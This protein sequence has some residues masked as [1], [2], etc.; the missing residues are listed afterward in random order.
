MPSQKT[1]ENAKMQKKL[2]HINTSNLVKTNINLL[3]INYIQT[4]EINVKNSGSVLEEGVCIFVV[5]NSV[6]NDN[7][8]KNRLYWGGGCCNYFMY[9][10]I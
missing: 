3:I 4:Y 8:T 1:Q 2:L 10:G 9:P 7:E 6:H 5:T